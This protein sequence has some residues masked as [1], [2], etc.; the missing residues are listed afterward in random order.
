MAGE[1]T[2][3]LR[4]M[5]A[6][7]NAYAYVDTGEAFLAHNQHRLL[8]KLPLLHLN[9]QYKMLTCSLM[10]NISGCMCSS[11]RP[12]TLIRPRPFLQYATAVAVFCKKSYSSENLDNL[13]TQVK[14]LK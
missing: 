5:T 11:G 3:H 10:R 8:Y 1:R 14:K 4:D 13:T 6:A 12:F 9:A 2:I 7:F